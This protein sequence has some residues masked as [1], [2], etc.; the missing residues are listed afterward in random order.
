MAIN[1]IQMRLGKSMAKL[2][3]KYGTE[4][5]CPQALRYSRRP[6]GLVCPAC[7]CRF[8]MYA[9]RYLA[10]FQYRF[11]RRYDLRCMLPSL[12]RAAANTTAWPEF[13]LKRAEFCT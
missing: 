5:Q 13:Q 9:P 7:R 2:M 3:R 6:D 8:Y 11:N 4:S 1:Q 12:L 10:A